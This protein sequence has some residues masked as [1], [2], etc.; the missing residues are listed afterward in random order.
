MLGFKATVAMAVPMIV[1]LPIHYSY[2]HHIDVT[3]QYSSY[4]LAFSL[5]DL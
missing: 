2:L 5:F 1:D 3:C 4:Q